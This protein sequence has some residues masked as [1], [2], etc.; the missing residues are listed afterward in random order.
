MKWA[1]IPADML[2]MALTSNSVNI[3]ELERE[4]IKKALE[5]QKEQNGNESNPS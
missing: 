3:G 2:Q 5:N 1:D 4:E